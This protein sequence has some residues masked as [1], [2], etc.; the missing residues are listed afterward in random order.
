MKKIFSFIGRWQWSNDHRRIRFDWSGFAIRFSF[1][2]SSIGVLLGNEFPVTSLGSTM[3]SIFIDDQF[4]SILNMT[5]PQNKY[6][7]T[8][9][10]T[11]SLHSIEIYK[12]TE[13]LFGISYFAGV[14]LDDFKNVSP[15][16]PGPPRKIELV[17]ASLTCGFGIE[18]TAPCPF[19]APT[20][21]SF[22]AHGDLIGRHF[23]ADY[24]TEC[25]SG[26]GVVKNN[27][28]PN[29]TSNGTLPQLWRQTL[30]ND[31]TT[32]FPFPR[33]WIADAV[34]INLGTN[35]YS[36]PPYPSR[37]VFEK[38]YQDFI[39]FILSHYPKTHFFL[40]CGPMISGTVCGFV[41]DVVTQRLKTYPYITYI[42]MQ[43]ILNTTDYGCGGHPNREGNLKMANIAIPIIKQTMHW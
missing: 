18:G 34:I 43:N 3:F 42:D 15:P 27:G 36:A 28:S 29:A 10:L 9:N 39:D 30:A 21:N 35:D 37:D 20:E 24:R 25:W 33:N 7:L 19:T 11:N 26:K 1:E 16:K 14:Y 13:A 41:E 5:Y 12:R 22:F 32:I 4:Y 6:N 8:S 31:N 17:G 2:G 38:G 40:E 23:N